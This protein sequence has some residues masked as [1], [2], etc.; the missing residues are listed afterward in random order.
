[1]RGGTVSK[2]F[3]EGM[4]RRS[5]VSAVACAGALASLGMSG[6]GASFYEKSGSS[7]DSKQ[8]SSEEKITWAHCSPNCYGRCALRV[9]T[10]DDEVIRVETDN[11]GNDEFGDHQIR[12][13]QRGRSMRR[14]IN[15]P[16]RLKYPMKR[17]GK[18]GS[19]EFERISWEEAIDL[20]ANKYQSVL[21]QYGPEAV[22]IAPASGVKAQNISDFL[23]RFCNCLGGYVNQS[24]GYSMAQARDA[25]P[26]MYGDRKNNSTADLANAKLCVMFGDNHVSNKLGGA[27]DCYQITNALEKGGAKVIVIDPR[28]SA[29]AGIR[30]DQWIPIRPGTDAALA[31]AIAYV[32]IKENKVDQKFLDDYCIGYDE[33]TLPVTAPA[34][35]DYKSHIL[36]EGP[37][38]TAKTPEWASPITGIPVKVIE[39]LAHEIADTAPCFIMQGLGPQRQ[40]NG[41]QTVRAICMLSVL[42]GGPGKSG[43]GTGFMFGADTIKG[44]SVPKG[45][46]GVPFTVPTFMYI[47]A[48]EDFTKITKKTAN[49][50]GGDKLLQPIKLLFSHGGNSLTNQHGNI[51]RSHKILGDESLCEM[52]VVWETMM[53]DSAKYADILLPDLMPSEQPSFAVGEYCGNMGYAILGTACTEPKFERMSLYQSLKLLAQKMGVEEDFTQGLDEEGWL[54]KIYETA[55]ESDAKL[56]EWEEMKEMGVYRRLHKDGGSIAYKDWREDPEGHPLGTPSGKIE[57]YSQ[58]LANLSESWVL[59]EGDVISPI[60]IY[61]PESEWGYSDPRRK[62]YPLQMVGFHERGHAHSSFVAIDVLQKANMKRFWINTEDAKER[63]IKNDDTVQVFNEFGRMEVQ[64]KVTDRI[65]P[66]VTAMGQGYWFEDNGK[67]VDVGSCI[68]TLT[69]SHP[70]PLAKAIPAHTNLVQVEKVK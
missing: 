7:G 66:G 36:G 12:A 11:T 24:G 1:M 45:T 8:A 3:S 27:G 42:L 41:E 48:I 67:G 13:C 10:K 58:K 68:N 40:Q 26:Y 64:A 31:Q 53:T 60:P 4:S 20:I 59:G 54:K 62:D 63:G 49:L 50:K 51:N 9:V 30:A 32:L 19:G 34:K 28:F 16:D 35:S 23:G 39:D 46:N 6:C 38:G 52:I 33:K 21:D 65:M 61:V 69:T 56:P 47:D 57:V 14:W 70:S 5:F 15:H 55:R 44:V 25:V 29:T 17:T 2:Q 37:D 18:R 43:V 22:L